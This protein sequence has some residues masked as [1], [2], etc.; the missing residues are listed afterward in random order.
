MTSRC[1]ATPTSSSNGCST[2]TSTRCR[3]TRW[4]CYGRSCGR[5]GA[6]G[7]AE[8]VQRALVETLA[9]E[10]YVNLSVYR[11][12]AGYSVAQIRDALGT[13]VVRSAAGTVLPR[14]LPERAEHRRRRRPGRNAPRDAP[15]PALR[16]PGVRSAVPAASSSRHRR[17][18]RTSGLTTTDGARQ[19]RHVALGVTAA[20]LRHLGVAQSTVGR[21]PP[22]SGRARRAGPTGRA[23][24][25][26]NGPARWIEP[27]RHGGTDVHMVLSVWHGDDDPPPHD[28]AGVTTVEALTGGPPPRR[29]PRRALRLRRRHHQ[30]AVPSPRRSDEARLRPARASSCSATRGSSATRSCASPTPRCPE[31]RTGSAA[32]GASPCCG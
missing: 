3:A 7:L 13:G 22:R 6:G 12:Y 8:R 4:S 19:R 21:F 25:G 16:G 18:R 23:T 27:L 17:R 2:T 30:P 24:S 5:D 29:A 10:R 9:R 15:A 26:P 28:D 32:T 1:A 14:H 20:G 31:A 11:G